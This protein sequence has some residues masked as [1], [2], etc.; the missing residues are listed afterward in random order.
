M[1]STRGS[2]LRT[3]KT[4]KRAPGKAPAKEQLRQLCP[5]LS[6]YVKPCEGICKHASGRSPGRHWML[7]AVNQLNAKES[8]RKNSGQ[9]TIA[10]AMS[11]HIQLCQGICKNA[12]ETAPRRSTRCS[13]PRTHQTPKKAPERTAAKKHPCQLCP[14]ISIHVQ[15]CPA[16]SKYMQTWLSKST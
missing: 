16:T 15:L 4:P 10:L 5:A 1:E 13:S 6:S 2:S 8:T 7:L 12:S 3:S 9:R 14:A 11:S